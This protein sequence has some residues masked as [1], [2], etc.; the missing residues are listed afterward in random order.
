MEQYIAGRR[1]DKFLKR[2]KG[3]KVGGR[4]AEWT[5]GKMN[6]QKVGGR[7][8]GGRKV[9]RTVGKLNGRRLDKKKD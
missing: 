5:V 3:R 8:I 2:R 6:G 4:K 9:E 1:E 7:K